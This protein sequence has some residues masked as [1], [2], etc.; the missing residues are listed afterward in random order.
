[1]LRSNKRV[2]RRLAVLA[3]GLTALLAAPVGSSA[4]AAAV[5]P[6]PSSVTVVAAAPA[7]ANPGAQEN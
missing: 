1:M 7:V 2:P 4:A 5:Q 3:G 6:A